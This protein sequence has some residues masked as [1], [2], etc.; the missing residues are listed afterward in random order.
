[1]VHLAF[2]VLLLGVS[3]L[4]IF[5]LLRFCPDDTSN[6][7]ENIDYSQKHTKRVRE[8]SG[9]IVLRPHADDR[10]DGDRRDGGAAV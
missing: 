10:L 4:S 2:I 3:T 8:A 9:T 7:A 6:G 1:M 5:T